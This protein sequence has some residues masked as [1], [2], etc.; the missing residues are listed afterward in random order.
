MFNMRTVKASLSLIIGL[1]ISNAVLS[2]Q[3]FNMATI[4][5]HVTDQTGAVV[6]NTL[7]TL[8]QQE[9]S[10]TRTTPTN[11]D[12][13]FEIASVEPGTYRLSIAGAGFKTFVAE[14][15]I[16]R[17]DEVR[18]VNA[19]LE[20]GA[21]TT[22]VTVTSGASVIT[23]DS[24]KIEGSSV[25][26]KKY[27]DSPWI[28]IN[29]SFVPQ[30]MLY[31][32]PQIQQ[33]GKSPGG[34]W[35]GQ[36]T[37]QVQQGEDG[38]NND[39]MA[40]QLN[41]VFDFS[42]LVIVTGNP[43]A[44]ISRVGYFNQVIKSGSNQFHGQFV[45]MNVNTA[46]AARP[47]FATSKTA[48]LQNTT[49]NGV[50]GPIIKNKTFFY[51]SWN[52]ANVKPSQYFLLS[53]PTA[54]M[55]T[56]DFSQ[57]LS[58]A[59]PVVIKDPT[60]N[61]PFPNNVI[62]MSRLSPLALKFVQKFMPTP[63]LGGP[64]NLANNVG[65]TFPWGTDLHTRMDN[66]VR[67]DH[68]LTAKNRVMFHFVR[69]R[70]NYVEDA[71]SYPGLPRTRQRFN[72]NIVAEDTHIFSPTLVNTFRYGWNR[73]KIFDG[74]ELFGVTPPT[75]DAVV[76]ALGLQG[77][78][79]Q[80]LSAQGFPITT[81]SGL[82]TFTQIAG[83]M[84]WLDHNTGFA[85]SITW[86]KGRHVIKIGA[87]YKPFS[88]LNQSIQTGTYGQFTFNG[89]FTGYGFS[90]LILGIPYSSSRLNQLPSR[91]ETDMEF[92]PYITDDF[93]VNSRL[94]MSMGVRWDRF[95]SPN[96]TDGLLWNWNLQ[97][98][99]IVVPQAAMNS[100]SPLYPKNIPIVAGQVRQN[101]SNLNIA[102]RFGMAYRLTDRFVVRG[103]YG[104]YTETLGRYSLLNSAGPFQILETYL[105]Q[106]VGGAPQFTFPNPFPST[107]ASASTAQS[108]AG[109]P[110]NTQNGRIH[111]F[112]ATLERQ[113]KDIGLRLTY[114]G[115][116]DRGMHYSINL[117]QPPPSLTPFTQA[118]RPWPNFVG[119]TY[120]R[121]NGA[122]DYN[123]MTIELQRKAGS[124]TFDVHY[125]LS[126]NMSNMLNLE[127][128]DATLSWN[129][130]PNTSRNRFVAN[131]VWQIPVG[132]GQKFLSGAP[133]I[134]NGILGGWQLYWIGL[135]ESGMYFSPS[136]SGSSPS[137]TGVSGGLPNRICNG[138]LPAGQRS[139]TNWFNASCFVV[140]SAGQFG[141]SG[142]DVLEG[143]GNHEENLSLIKAFKLSERLHFTLTGSAE[144]FINHANFAIP[145]ANISSPGTV[146]TISA[147]NVN[148]PR[149]IELRGRLD[150]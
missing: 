62:P 56:G 67:I 72:Y 23:T 9:T 138:N 26:L 109:Y 51:T 111:Q 80:N 58:I 79:P 29:S 91:T 8:V 97:T 105:N 124:V 36:N 108:F 2:A 149:V 52:Y 146:G 6:V 147:I 107:T 86:S 22:E 14:N 142:V 106:V 85:D 135:V 35:A 53:V 75:G 34:Q 32:T 25:N 30:F 78:N 90:D 12:G 4:R 16:L 73:E 127:N 44:D 71:S 49:A 48:Q 43:T 93:K 150:F 46:L 76:K 61:A 17:S 55:Q 5:G 81:I 7:V 70:T 24:A 143:P 139:V 74:G 95:G 3:V 129:R 130:D 33:V 104:I 82:S 120:E 45:Y 113:F 92:G 18:R 47:F 77:V 134:V 119:G 94:T 28:N 102:P 21:A 42:E 126:S 128:P 131:M 31:S 101:P 114:L 123:A 89:T 100:I 116:R 99:D 88:F 137:N 132:K 19:A 144:N 148:G 63:N 39:G 117:D 64:N 83:G 125:T 38:Q 140:P 133:A 98:G 50:S 103:A 10:A 69:D 84:S 27:P 20:L 141:N 59:K 1:L 68:Y 13:D 122:V 96:F 11:S 112:N 136:Y 110:L 40:N 41:D 65:W 60:T 145:A 87:E 57:L 121:S 15:I 54:Q 118:L 115:A 37:A 66:T